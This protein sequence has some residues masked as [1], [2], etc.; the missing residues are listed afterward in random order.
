MDALV[1]VGKEWENKYQ[2][3][4]V[5]CM[6]VKVSSNSNHVCLSF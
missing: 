2:V 6:Y 4:Q 1:S 5:A 3:L